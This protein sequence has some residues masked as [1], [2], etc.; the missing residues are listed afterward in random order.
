[1]QVFNDRFQADSGCS[2]LTVLGN[3]HQIPA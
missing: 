1:M 2:T 3:G